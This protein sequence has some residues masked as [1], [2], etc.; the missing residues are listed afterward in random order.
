MPNS[1]QEKQIDGFKQVARD[2][3]CD[4][5]EAAFDEMLGKLAK[6]KPKLIKKTKDKKTPE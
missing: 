1:H 3:G 2:L 5:N 6:H 4:E